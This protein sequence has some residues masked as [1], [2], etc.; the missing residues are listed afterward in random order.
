ME[1]A[2]PIDIDCV[3]SYVRLL[4]KVESGML[5]HGRLEAEREGPELIVQ[6]W[7]SLHGILW[8]V[9]GFRQEASNFWKE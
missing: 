8:F 9:E 3:L 7:Q 5:T 6:P 2:Y 1:G 4:G